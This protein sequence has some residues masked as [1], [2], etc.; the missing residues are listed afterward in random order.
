[1]CSMSKLERHWDREIPV[2][3]VCALR[4]SLCWLYFKICCVKMCLSV[5]R[6]WSMHEWV[7]WANVQRGGQRTRGIMLLSVKGNNV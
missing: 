6:V 2:R 4:E 5:E 7:M 1:M 3:E